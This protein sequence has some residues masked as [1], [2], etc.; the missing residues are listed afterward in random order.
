MSEPLTPERLREIREREHIATDGPWVRWAD[1]AWIPGWD[2]MCV[3]GDDAAEGE[4]C[5]PIAR[6]HVDEDAAFIAHARRDVPDLL[7]EVNRLKAERDKAVEAAKHMG[8]ALE[9][10]GEAM[11]HAVRTAAAQGNSAGM[12]IVA[13]YLA[14][15]GA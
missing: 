15:A 6:V 5:N 9:K 1:Q 12:E 11:D 4:E 8:S 14:E 10:V 3:I 7:A 13:S 2:G